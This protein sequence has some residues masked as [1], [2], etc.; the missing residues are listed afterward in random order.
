MSPGPG[1]RP[2]YELRLG[3]RKSE[4]TK[5]TVW[6]MPRARLTARF[7]ETKLLPTPGFGLQM[8]MVRDQRMGQV[9]LRSGETAVID[10]RLEPSDG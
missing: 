1:G 6:S 7:A 9:S 3:R 5:S 2:K 10:V 4:S 8:P